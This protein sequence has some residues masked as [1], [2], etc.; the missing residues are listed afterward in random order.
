MT[1]AAKAADLDALARQLHLTR[2]QRLYAEGL[3]TGLSGLEAAR[4]AGYNGGDKG[5]A[6]RVAELVKNSRVQQYMRALAEAAEAPLAKAAWGAVL[7]RRAI[8]RRLSAQADADMGRYVQLGEHGEVQGLRIP[9][10]HTRAVRSVE[11]TEDVLRSDKEEKVLRRR[12]KL[13]VA[14]PTPAAAK[15][16]D[17]YGMAAGGGAPP[18]GA[19]NVQII[20]LVGSVQ[21]GRV[22]AM[23]LRA[24]IERH[25]EGA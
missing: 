2:R 13:R 18:A 4:R 8:L 17:I 5:R 21:G 24:T 12:V 15:L 25:M 14:D 6:T 22:Q 9:R 19:I 23:A 10:E 1:V 7:G 3:V 16:A 11:I 20:N